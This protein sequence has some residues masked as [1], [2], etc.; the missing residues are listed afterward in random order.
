MSTVTFVSGRF[1]VRNRR[2]RGL[3]GR[4]ARLT[5]PVRMRAKALSANLGDVPCQILGHKWVEIPELLRRSATSDGKRMR[6]RC[7]RCYLCNLT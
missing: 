4:V 7:A 1:R 2:S 3:G 5:W 6:L